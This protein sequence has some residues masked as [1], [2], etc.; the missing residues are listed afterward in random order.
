MET[1]FKDMYGNEE[2]NLSPFYVSRLPDRAGVLSTSVIGQGL[3]SRFLGG[4][5][6]PRDNDAARCRR[7]HFLTFC[8]AI[9]WSFNYPD[10]LLHKKAEPEWFPRSGDHKESRF[11]HSIAL[12]A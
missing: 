11:V 2:Y 8:I 5:Q 9:M 7:R 10:Q 3:V 4:T 12:A 6:R 1:N